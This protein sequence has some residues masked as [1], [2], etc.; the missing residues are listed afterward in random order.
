LQYFA[1]G[2]EDAVLGF[3]LAGVRGRV[4]RNALEASGAFQEALSREDTGIII[5]TERVAEMIRREVDSYVFSERFPLLVE[6]PDRSGKL[7]GRPG[8]RELVNAAIGIKL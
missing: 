1:I 3:S 7:E 5:M 2:D 8:T 4:A 6:V